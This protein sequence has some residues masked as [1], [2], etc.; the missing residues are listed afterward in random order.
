MHSLF[1]TTKIF[2]ATYKFCR[3][4]YG[5]TPFLCTVTGGKHDEGYLHY[6]YRPSSIQRDSIRDI[7]N[8]RSDRDCMALLKQQRNP[9]DVKVFV[10]KACTIPR[11]IVRMNYTIVKNKSKADVVLMPQNNDLFV[12]VYCPVIVAIMSNGEYCRVNLHKHNNSSDGDSTKLQDL[13]PTIKTWLENKFSALCTDIA[14]WSSSY[15]YQVRKC[16]EYADLIDDEGAY[17]MNEYSH[18]ALYIKEYDIPLDNVS[19]PLS[20]EG[21]AMM[22]RQTDTKILEKLV[23]GSDWTEYPFTMYKFLDLNLNRRLRSS[24]SRSTLAVIDTLNDRFRHNYS[25]GAGVASA[26]D[27]NLYQDFCLAIMGIQGEKGLAPLGRYLDFSRLFSDM[28]VKIAMMKQPVSSPVEV[29]R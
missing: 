1:K 23:T 28:P 8:D 7:A 29:S 24:L 10:S 27:Y 11:D 13:V 26:K 15:L 4:Q 19:N 9:K 18:K 22:T 16:E 5:I 12:N 25:G 20:G 14:Y 6:T 2:Y 17:N 21:L 3:N